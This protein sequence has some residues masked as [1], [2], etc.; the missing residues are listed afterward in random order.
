MLTSTVYTKNLSKSNKTVSMYEVTYT[1]KMYKSSHL[2]RQ[3][4]KRTQD[5]HIVNITWAKVS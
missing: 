1:V 3:W 5:M 4:P 2:Q